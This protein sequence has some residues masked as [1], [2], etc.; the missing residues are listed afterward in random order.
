MSKLIAVLLVLF[1][2]TASA[3]DYGKLIEF[4]TGVYVHSLRRTQNGGLLLGVSQR[5]AVKLSPSGEVEWQKVGLAQAIETA[6]GGFAG[7]GV[8]NGKWFLAKFNRSQQMQWQQS[9]TFDATGNVVF[10]RLRAV[11][12]VGYIMAGIEYSR[13]GPRKCLL[14]LTD[15]QGIPLW[16]RKYPGF[17]LRDMEIVRN[18]SFILVGRPNIT[19]MKVSKFGDLLY[20]GI[21]GTGSEDPESIQ[22]TLDG[23]FVIAS[24]RRI[25]PFQS[26]ITKISISNTGKVL[27]RQS[28]TGQP[29]LIFRSVRSTREGYVVSGMRRAA[30]EPNQDVFVMQLNNNG[31]V[32][33]INYFGGT[34]SEFGYAIATLDNRFAIAGGT[35]SETTGNEAGFV[36][37]FPRT[38]NSGN[39][40]SF[41]K[42]YQLPI[43]QFLVQPVPAIVKQTQTIER[44]SINDESSAVVI[45]DGNLEFTD[46]CD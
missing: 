2:L 3:E 11:G 29:R 27:W 16:F 9:Y 8:N 20:K 26:F 35:V 46:L 28:F 10:M 33:W 34:A 12:G 30:N 43:T 40:C 36:F 42:S 21:F 13:T 25:S 15:T 6:D 32:Q 14:L 5:Y 19:V 1:S 24:N 39:F 37:K 38:Q 31:I 17:N 44:P 18:E 41:F 22:P 7:I 4:G 45:N 23:N